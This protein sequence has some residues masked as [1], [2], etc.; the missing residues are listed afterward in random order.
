LDQIILVTIELQTG[1]DIVRALD[2]AKLD[3]SVA[4]YAKLGEYERR[5]MV[6]A[7]RSFDVEPQQK[8]YRLFHDAIDAAGI[9]YEN[10]P[11][12]RIFSTKSPFVRELR[13]RY[14]PL[15]DTTI[16]LQSLGGH[17]IEDAYVYRIR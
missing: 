6:I 13:R 3:V 2:K 16:G 1:A 11:P 12:T 7:G 5:R 9:R 14:K 10:T 17:F 15:E 4:L 8:G